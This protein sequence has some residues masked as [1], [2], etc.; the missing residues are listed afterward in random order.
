MIDLLSKVKII[1]NS[2]G[3]EGR[4]LKVLKAG[5][6][7][8]IVGDVIVVSVTKI[9][10]GSLIQKGDVHKALII[11]TKRDGSIRWADNA[12]ILIKG[13]DLS[14]VGTRIRGPISARIVQPKLR[15]LA[16]FIV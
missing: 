14:P 13:M 15:S 1:D 8:G 4:C 6:A 7:P 9:S 16:K 5:R 12:A 2:G 10:S 3:L 11:R